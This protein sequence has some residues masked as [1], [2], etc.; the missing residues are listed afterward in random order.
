MT[1]VA[2]HRH[3]ARLAE[4]PR[5]A[6]SAAETSARHYCAGILESLGFSVVEEPFE[7]SSWPGR[8]ATPVA[9]VASLLLLT[10]AAYFGSNGNG[11]IALMIIGLG[12]SV[13]IPL[14]I[15][16]ARRGVL[17]LRYGR[18]RGVNLRATRGDPE[19]AVWLM[20]HL[21][22]K[23]QPVPTAARAAGMVA[24]GAVVLIAIGVATAQALGADLDAWWIWI[25]IAGALV[26][27]PV[28]ASVVGPHSP[29]ALDNASGVAT[30]LTAVARLER[31]DAVGV[32]LTSA[33]ELGLA[34]A[35]AVARRYAPAFALNCDGV[36]DRGTLICMR[37]GRRQS[38][39]VTAL[40]TAAA[41]ANV[42]LTVR[43]L[44]PGLLVDAVALHDAGWDCATLSRG[45][46]RTLARVHR[47]HDDLEH[48]TGSG[49]DEAALVMAGAV[50][51]LRPHFQR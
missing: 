45:S 12:M 2:A 22:S 23:S 11:V 43:G 31:R 25:A 41:E 21:D 14:G 17:E 3:L 10:L 33:E 8:W 51:Q 34:G 35:R 40:V 9:G 46:W 42:A 37:S 19:P 50:R 13:G 27:I 24:L 20:A 16:M 32:L 39:S 18:A 15:W 30:V 48:L 26:V 28:E 44:V 5:P 7:Y 49:I 29:G 4:A 6:G 38:R 47:P 1:A 36:D